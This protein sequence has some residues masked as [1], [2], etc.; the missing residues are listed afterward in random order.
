MTVKGLTETLTA[1]ER[2][3]SDP[4]PGPAHREGLKKAKRE[5]RR[6]SRSGKLDRRQVFRVTALISATLCEALVLTPMTD[7]RFH[8]VVEQGD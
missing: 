2:V 7:D 6:I 1:L 5:L 4:R 8:Q 3:L